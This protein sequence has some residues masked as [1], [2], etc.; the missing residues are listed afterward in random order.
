M[1]QEIEK[2]NKSVITTPFENCVIH[3]L[4][5]KNLRKQRIKLKS[6]ISGYGQTIRELIRQV[7][8]LVKENDFLLE[9]RN[10]RL[11]IE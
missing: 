6:T 4:Y 1:N 10:K 3:C 9:E 11:G 2:C 8:K 7:E 5:V